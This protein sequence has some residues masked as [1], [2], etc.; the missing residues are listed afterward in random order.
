MLSEGLPLQ[1]VQVSVMGNAHKIALDYLKSLGFSELVYEPKGNVT[2]DFLLNGKIAIE[3]RRLN[4]HYLRN[5]VYEPLE[6]LFYRI[7]PKV[8][9]L[10]REVKVDNFGSV[11]LT[12]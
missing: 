5:G 8:M 12:V 2:P 11:K 4:Q 9:K 3:V 10:L 1:R 7:V 6:E